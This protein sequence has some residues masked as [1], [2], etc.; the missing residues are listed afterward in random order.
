MGR[1]SKL[2]FDKSG[3]RVGHR[4]LGQG[5]R[6]ICRGIIVLSFLNAFLWRQLAD[7]NGGL[8]GSVGVRLGTVLIGDNGI[9]HGLSS[10]FIGKGSK[11]NGA[12]QFL[13][14]L[15]TGKT[16]TYEFKHS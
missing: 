1:Y 6:G 10:G 11:V 9:L 7:G 5:R 13:D 8:F 14:L 4:W 3:R 12:A 2:F 16:Q 15:G